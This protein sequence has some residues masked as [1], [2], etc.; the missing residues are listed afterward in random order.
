MLLGLVAICQQATQ[1]YP[2]VC[3]Y[4]EN[5]GQLLKVNN[6]ERLVGSAQ[7]LIN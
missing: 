4:D 6:E 7:A 3:K 1:G 2:I 5:R